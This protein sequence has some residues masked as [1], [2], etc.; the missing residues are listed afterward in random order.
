VLKCTGARRT[1]AT[2]WRWSRRSAK[3]SGRRAALLLCA[4]WIGGCGLV[5]AL[6]LSQR[7]LPDAGRDLPD[8]VPD[9][10]GP[11]F[12][13]TGINTKVLSVTSLVPAHGPFGGG[14]EVRVRGS[15]F[16]D[17]ALVEIGGR[18]VQPSE[19]RRLD[20]NT[21][22][23][24]VPAGEIGPADVT[25]LVGE[26]QVTLEDGYSYN[27]L[28][29]EPDS[30]SE[31]GGTRVQ[32]T[33]EG[34]ELD[35]QVAVRFGGEPCT[36]LVIVTPHKLTC[37]SPRGSEGRVDVEAFWQDDSHES[38]LAQDAFEYRDTADP[39]R[40]GLSGGPIDGA[41][42]VT[43]ID[44]VFGNLVPD[45]FVLIGDG[46]ESP[47]QGLTDVRG[48]IT[49]SDPALLGRVSVHA[50]KKCFEK[51]S[52]VAFDAQNVTLFLE[53]ILDPSCVEL[54]G[55]GEG[56]P[57]RGSAGSTIA[58]ELLFPGLDEFTTSDWGIVPKP[59]ENEVRVAY[60]YTTRTRADAPNPSPFAVGS[61]SRVLETTPIGE[62]GYPYRI[63]A[64]PAGLAV[65]A[66]A[67]VERIDTG[68][69]MPYV[70]GVARDVLTAPGEETA[71]VDI[72]MSI[73]LDRS[74]RVALGEL[75][76]GTP[77]GPDVY[78]V[79]AH[80]DLGGEG[81]IVRERNGRL[82][83]ARESFTAGA[84]FPFLAQPALIGELRDARYQLVSGWYTSG[85]S[86][87]PY[88]QMTTF[89]VAQ[90]P[91]PV[92][93]G[94]FLGIPQQSLPLEGQLLPA[95]R[96]ISWQA[97][98]APADMYVVSVIGGDGSPAWTQIL[99]GSQTWTILPDLSSIPDIQDISAGFISWQVRGVKIDGFVYDEFRYGYLSPRL[100]TH[101]AVNV[102]LM[103][104]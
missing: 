50:A 81:V 26:E 23:I 29:V 85:A 96:T 8:S 19:T 2:R 88:T 86:A 6:T 100:W 79:Q 102:F 36:E 66:L 101:D 78:A 18:M 83:D 31:A 63:F 65:Y 93:L 70:M 40:G 84:L 28:L 49:F 9:A 54:G 51:G 38:L 72:E 80:L 89:G 71:A 25:V 32:I 77:R 104:R 14:N 44:S 55:G 94:G 82:M 15:G 42:N 56:V 73:T 39:S 4:V 1:V 45:A 30:G 3:A 12:P 68:E 58:G 37:R 61:E 47:W 62:R 46:L 27:A 11:R 52:I 41:L 95:D 53:P 57:G 16:D 103:K 67:G 21:L 92:E 90:S 35:D 64:R 20:A 5:D 98:A 48:Q 75:P 59:L 91:E 99:P 22:S 43:V 60:V 69:F 7:P 74:L 76:A 34:S 17:E 33:V 24:V 10:G 87:A 13:Q 97:D